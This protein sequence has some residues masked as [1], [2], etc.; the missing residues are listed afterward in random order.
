MTQQ[1]EHMKQAGRPRRSEEQP[2]SPFG[3]ALKEHLRRVENFTQAEVA[4]ESIIAEKT[5]SHM[6]KGKR[7]DGPALRRDLRAIIKVLYQRQ[8]LDT[9]EEANALLSAIPAV[10]ELDPR[11]PE[12]AKI[13]ALFLP[14]EQT[15]QPTLQQGAEATASF[16]PEEAA[17][18]QAHLDDTDAGETDASSP[19]HPEE[20]TASLSPLRGIQR[21]PRYAATRRTG[22]LVA[23][24]CVIVGSVL[25][26]AAVA[27][28]SFWQP[29]KTCSTHG[30]ILYTDIQYQGH[31]A[32]FGPGDYELAQFGLEQKVSSLRDPNNAYHIT[33]YDKAKNFY[34]IDK[35]TPVFP[36]EWDNRADTIHVEKHRPTT[37]QPGPNGIIAFLNTDYAGGCLFITQDIPDLTPFNFDQVMVSLQF[38]GTYQDTR[39]LLL[40][41]QPNYQGFCG[42]YWQDQSDLLQCARLALSV[43]VLPFTPPTPVPTVA[44]TTYAGNVAPYATLSPGNAQAAVDGNLQTEWIGGHQVALELQW[45]L[46]VTIHRVVVWDRQQSA[47]DNNQINTLKL[48]FSDGTAT[49]SLDMISQGPR[50]VDVSLPV[51]TLRWLQIIP[52][53]A[54]GNNGL[55]E[56]EVWAT[57]GP[58]YSHNTCVNQRTVPQTLPQTSL[59]QTHD[60]FNFYCIGCYEMGST[61]RNREYAS[62][63][64]A[65]KGYMESI[66]S[67]PSEQ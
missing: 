55:R 63:K 31:C 61:P 29:T 30:V 67:H 47:S 25:S 23:V 33:L 59:A 4:R 48:I 52:V 16:P 13:L 42:A 58:Q 34:D 39:Q 15:S 62:V 54:S 44:G 41:K 49:G 14:V 20:T 66:F 50:C 26:I 43:R 65:L 27:R 1:G 3:K 24:L 38:V 8:A 21:Q 36:A 19:P 56:V 12:D 45:T 40:Y 51:K 6:V 9:L 37:C 7:R 10:K 64:N 28:S 46:P 18:D 60:V 22:S 2:D 11:D 17:Q 35:D 57:T 32:T 5:L 53:D